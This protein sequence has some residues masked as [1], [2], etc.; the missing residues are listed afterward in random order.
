MLKSNIQRAFESFEGSFGMGLGD[1]EY[2]VK[3]NKSIAVGSRLPDVSKIRKRPSHQ[4]GS[5]S[6]S[7]PSSGEHMFY[8]TE[9]C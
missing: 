5:D 3:Q 1:R 6:S 8:R 2:S 4:H 7:D 9:V